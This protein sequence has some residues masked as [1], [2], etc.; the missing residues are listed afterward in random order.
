MIWSGLYTVHGGF[1]DWTNDGLGIL[2]FSNELW[3][4]GQCFQQSGAQEQQAQLQESSCAACL[5]LLLRRPAGV[6]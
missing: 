4:N 5:E 1:I 6:R 3:N 2:S